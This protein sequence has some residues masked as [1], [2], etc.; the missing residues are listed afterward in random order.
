MRAYISLI[1]VIF[2]VCLVGCGSGGGGSDPILEP[3]LTVIAMTTTPADP[4]EGTDF[5]LNVTIQNVGTA[6]SPATVVRLSQ[7][8]SGSPVTLVDAAVPPLPSTIGGNSATI[9]VTMTGFTADTYVFGALV[10]PGATFPEV[11]NANNSTAT[12]VTVLPSGPG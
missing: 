8:V 11:S 9:Q 7:S 3:D 5:T 4:V 2:A 10:N 1:A 6:T 12:T